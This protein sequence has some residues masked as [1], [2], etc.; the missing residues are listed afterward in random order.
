MDLLTASD[1]HDL[2]CIEADRCVSI[3]L[4]THP[5]GREGQ[6]DAVRLN[7][8]VTAAEQQLIGRGMRGVEAT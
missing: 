2:V 3:Y 7:N 8:L 6:Q 5:T 1:L 4:P